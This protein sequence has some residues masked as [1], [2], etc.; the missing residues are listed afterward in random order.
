M[1]RLDWTIHKGRALGSAIADKTSPLNV[2]GGLPTV[3]LDYSPL[4][5]ANIG[6]WTQ[7]AINN[8]YNARVID[9]FQALG[10]VQQGWIT[11]PGGQ[12]F[13]AS[14]IVINCPIVERSL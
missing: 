12:P 1:V 4:W 8:H 9:E 7:E 13:G 14:G 5:D 3:A 11:G 6:E 10:L 2:F